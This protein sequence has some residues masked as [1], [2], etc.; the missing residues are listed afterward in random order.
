MFVPVVA[1]RQEDKDIAVNCV[2]FEI[3]LQRLPMNLDVLHSDGLCGGVSVPKPVPGIW[4]VPGGG[5]E[6]PRPCDRRILSPNL[7]ILQRVASARSAA[8]NLLYII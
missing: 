4:L 3:A 5:V 1:E 2:A 7:T 8:Y 6:P